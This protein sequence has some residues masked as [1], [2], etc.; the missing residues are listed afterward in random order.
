[1]N[2]TL[3]K[4]IIG[5]VVIII[6]VIIVVGILMLP[7]FS[8]NLYP[9]NTT[10]FVLPGEDDEGPQ[11][12]Y[13]WNLL[14]D[15]IN[16]FTQVLYIQ[17][18]IDPTTKDEFFKKIDETIPSKYNITQYGYKV[19]D[20]I[21]PVYITYNMRNF[22]KMWVSYLFDDLKGQLNFSENIPFKIRKSIIGN[23]YTIS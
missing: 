17:D 12:V 9:N 19:E 21:E 10:A 20:K 2:T 23:L 7:I 4:V 8:C 3:T 5:L 16:R 15:S 1:M 14:L 18:G 11:P 13:N 22:Y 6:I